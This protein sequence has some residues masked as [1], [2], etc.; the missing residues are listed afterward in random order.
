MQ[1]D[2]REVYCLSI[3]LWASFERSGKVL[4]G[5]GLDR[6]SE[7]CPT[8]SKKQN[9]KGRPL[10]NRLKALGMRHPPRVA[11]S[12]C[13]RVRFIYCPNNPRPFCPWERI[14]FS[15]ETT[16]RLYLRNIARPWDH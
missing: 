8:L 11:L 14:V 9:R 1:K 10:K 6:L 12:H 5:R 15:L 13:G 2:S 16:P 4:N 3:T 7:E